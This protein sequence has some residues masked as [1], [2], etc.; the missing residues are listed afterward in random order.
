MKKN[1]NQKKTEPKLLLK[2]SEEK[3]FQSYFVSFQNILKA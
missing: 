2:S 3:P 1:T